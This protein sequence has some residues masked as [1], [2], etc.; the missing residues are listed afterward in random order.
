MVKEARPA[1]NLCELNRFTKDYWGISASEATQRKLC[2]FCLKHARVHHH[3]NLRAQLNDIHS[4][5][6]TFLHI[7][8]ATA[9]CR[10]ITLL[11]R[12]L[13]SSVWQCMATE[14]ADGSDK[15]TKPI[16]FAEYTVEGPSICWN[17]DGRNVER[18]LFKLMHGRKAWWVSSE[19]TSLLKALPLE[20]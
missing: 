14:C 3:A 4:L 1:H 9:E 13:Q 6:G 2:K 16:G 7:N 18:Q 19:R 5:G 20:L 8:T 15:T 11:K 17:K 12:S 10:L